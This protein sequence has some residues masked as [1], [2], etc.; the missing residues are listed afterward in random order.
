MPKTP[1]GLAYAFMLA[2]VPPGMS[3]NGPATIRVTRAENLITQAIQIIDEHIYT[4][5]AV[6]DLAKRIG[7]NARKLTLL[8]RKKF[9]LTVT[10][11]A[12]ELR[13]ELA[14]RL[15]AETDHQIQLI[16]ER[17]GYVNA[18]DFSRAFSRRY[19]QSPREYRQNHARQDAGNNAKAS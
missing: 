14:R 19:G 10:Q 3:P 16:G 18:G 12:A 1:A 11:Y 17:V 15:L 13:L 6:A 7:T 2:A 5:M 8:F 9:G 4:P